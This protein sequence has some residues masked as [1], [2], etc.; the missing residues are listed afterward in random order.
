MTLT[1]N[2]G[3]TWTLLETAFTSYSLRNVSWVTGKSAIY[4]RL[5]DAGSLASRA[6]QT[7]VNKLIT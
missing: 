6:V 2:N 7:Q 5:K 1:R 3:G 4:I